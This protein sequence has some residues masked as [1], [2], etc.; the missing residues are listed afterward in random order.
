M[1]AK[2]LGFNDLM[3]AVISAVNFIRARALNHRQFNRFMK[4]IDANYKDVLYFSQI[5]LL[6]RGKTLKRVWDSKLEI[7]FYIDSKRETA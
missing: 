5:R 3:N 7:E 2:A 6:S 4:E 1:S